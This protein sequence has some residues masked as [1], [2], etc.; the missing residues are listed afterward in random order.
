[1]VGDVLDP[2]VQG[3]AHAPG[4]DQGAEVGHDLGNADVYFPRVFHKLGTRKSFEF[5]GC[6][7]FNM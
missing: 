6:E 1:M 3:P 5:L 4:H 7:R 2:P